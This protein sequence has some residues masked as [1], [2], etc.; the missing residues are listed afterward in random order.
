MDYGACMYLV[1]SDGKLF[2]VLEVYK[3][4]SPI[5]VFKL[6]PKLQSTKEMK[7]CKMVWSRVRSLGNG[8]LHIS[9]GGSFLE[10]V[11]ARGMGNKICLPMILHKENIFYSL[12]TE[13][14][15]SPII[16]SGN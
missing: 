11:V 15:Q 7:S 3:D 14:Y 6:L 2:A 12:N 1:E 10:P 5:H 9:P 16:C 4:Q 13:M 8:M